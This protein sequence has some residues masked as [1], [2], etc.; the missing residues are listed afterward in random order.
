MGRGGKLDGMVLGEGGRVTAKEYLRQLKTLD[1]LIKAKE[2]EK[3]RL[4]SLA[5]KVSV[6]L[7]EKVQGGSGGVT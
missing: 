6:S 7:S 1:C 4:I 3:E 5:E 2:L